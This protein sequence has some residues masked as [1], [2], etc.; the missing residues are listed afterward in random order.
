LSYSTCVAESDAV[1]AQRA[2]L[3]EALARAGRGERAALREIYDLTSAKLF[4]VCLRICQEREAAEDVLQD[5]YLKIWSRAGRF[6]ASRASPITWLCTIARNAAIDWRRATRTP[7]TLDET[8]AAEVP[9]E[10]PLASDVIVATQSR[11]RIFACLDGLDERPRSAIRAAF[12]DGLSYPQLAQQ[13]AVPLGT[14]KSWV[15]RGLL[16]LKACLGDG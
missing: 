11:A 6:D 4:G 9:D 5:V 2:R 7:V 10:R 16:Q 15:R 1:D 3:V 13:M 8:A 14:M 12:F